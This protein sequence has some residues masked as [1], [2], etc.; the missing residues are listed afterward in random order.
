MQLSDTILRN[1][2]LHTLMLS[3]GCMLKSIYVDNIITGACWLRRRSSWTQPNLQR[4]LQGSIFQLAKVPDKLHFFTEEDW[5]YWG[6][7]PPRAATIGE[8]LS[9][10]GTNLHPQR[11]SHCRFTRTKGTWNVL[12]TKWRHT[13]VRRISAI[14]QVSWEPLNTTS[15]ASSEDF[16]IRWDSSLLWLFAPR[17]FSSSCVA[18][19]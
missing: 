16:M 4:N 3:I 8:S 11:F 12:E 6:R 15:P 5:F 18:V 13:I 17:F 9:T 7:L 2:Y 14:Y 1:T 19:R 10:S